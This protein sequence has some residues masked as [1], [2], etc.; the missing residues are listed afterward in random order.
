[1]RYTRRRILAGMAVGLA[2]VAGGPAA[3]PA[4]LGERN[5]TGPRATAA[6]P[7]TACS[8][9]RAYVQFVINV[10]DTVH[11]DESAATLL[12]AAALFDK[13]RVAGDFYLTGPMARL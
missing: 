12:R 1:M 7:T 4:A 5:R 9:P 2:M 13:Y 10:H 3:I 8:D 6:P 11:V